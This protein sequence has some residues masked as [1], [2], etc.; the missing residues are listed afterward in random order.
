MSLILVD[1]SS[2]IYL[3]R[4]NGDPIVRSGVEQ[5]LRSGQAC[6]CPLIQLELWNG[7]GGRQEKK[8]LREFAEVL[9]ELPITGGVWEAAYDLARRA[10]KHGVTIPASDLIIAACARYH[11]VELETADQDFAKLEILGDTNNRIK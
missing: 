4:P 6:W 7:A 8:V 11:Q 3:L 9:P 2:W 10:R 1:S 5:A